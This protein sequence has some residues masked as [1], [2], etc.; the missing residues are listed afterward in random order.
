[1]SRFAIHHIL[2]KETTDAPVN[3]GRIDAEKCEQLS[4]KLIDIG[5]M[6]EIFIC[7]PEEMIF[8]VKDWLVSY[9]ID[10]KKI[11]FELFTTPGVQYD[12]TQLQE[13]EKPELGGKNSKVTIRLDGIS[14]DFDLPYE[15][16]PILDGALRQGAD[17]PY[18]CKGGVC[19]TCRAK[20][21]EGKVDMDIN[22]ALEPEELEAG[23]ILTCQ[24]HPRTEK[25]V[26]DF[27][28]K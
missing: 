26:V 15:G 25:V 4:E 22:Y 21:I 28:V 20:L 1:M 3:F 17:L 2:S 14:F 11:H 5:S 23:F 6:D 27:D 19:S 10:K 18:A 9:G 8:T 16:D 12:K 13:T 24:S 7:G